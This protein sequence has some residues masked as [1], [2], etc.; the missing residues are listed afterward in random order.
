MSCVASVGGVSIE[1]EARMGEAGNP[2]QP[3]T[4]HQADSQVPTD[5]AADFFDT[6]FERLT[7]AGALR[8]D[9]R[10]LRFE[11]FFLLAALVAFFAAAFFAGIARA[12]EGLNE[13][14]DYT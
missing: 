2:D 1:A 5:L 3:Y 4:C 9:A 14:G 12:S 8:D 6:G 7:D 11:L 13:T 10:A